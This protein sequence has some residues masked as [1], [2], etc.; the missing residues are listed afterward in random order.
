MASQLH[1]FRKTNS[2]S[3]F[4]DGIRGIAGQRMRKDSLIW[5]SAVALAILT[6]ATVVFAV[7]NFQ[8]ERQFPKPYD[9]VWWLENKGPN[10]VTIEAR[11]V[12]AGGPGENA[13]I[14]PGDRLLAINDQQ[15]DSIYDINREL[16][17]T[18]VWSKARYELEHHGVKV[19]TSI[20]LV[21]ADNSLNQGARLI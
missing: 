2:T 15:V 3:T 17:R 11:R 1:S 14:K 7:I 21:D 20:I 8:K 19:E 16:A 12:A 5:V 10:G 9:G 13:G 4:R 6:A 18:G